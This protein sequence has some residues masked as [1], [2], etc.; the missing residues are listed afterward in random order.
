[1]SR[2]G[3]VG[4]TR[5]AAT[6]VL[7]I[8]LIAATS[9]CSSGPDPKPTAEALAA[10]LASGDL[11][12]V[13]LVG[14]T[15][16]DAATQLE[17]IT[18]GLAGLAPDVEVARIDEGE[19]ADGQEF[20]TVELDVTW[21]PDTATDSGGSSET[22]AGTSWSYT[23]T[24]R[25]SPTDDGWEVAWTPAI[26]H[27][28][29][30]DG[31]RLAV[32]HQQPVRGDILGTG[33]E[34]LVTRR[35]VYRIGIDK[36]QVEPAAAATSAQSLATLVDVDPAAFAGRVDAAGDRAFVEAI[37]LRDAEAVPV[38]ARLE[39]IP[40]AVA[41]EDSIPL[42]PTATFARPILGT[43]G[44]ATAEI[45][46]E[47]GGALAAGDV[48]G[49]SGL[50]ER[51]DD[52]LRG[53]PGT[54]IERIP[55]EGEASIM[56]ETDPVP[57]SALTTTL[58]LAL[59]ERAEAILA[60]VGPASAIVA[61]QPSTGN[62]LAAASGPGGEGYS[63]ATVGQYAPGSTFKVVTSLALLRA[64]LTADTMLQC[65]V[66]TTVDGKSFK[67]YDDYPSDGI[68]EIPLRSVVAN[69][70]NTALIGQQ[71]TVS[72][73]D[74]ASAAASLGLGV[75]HDLGAPTFLGE[76][77]AEADGTEHAASVIGQG[78][79]LAS[80]LAMATVA[81]SIA[82]G[83]T[84]VPRMVEPPAGPTAAP[85]AAPPAGAL[86]AAEGQQ[87]Q[88]LMRAVVE[89]GSGA[90]LADVPGDP[91]GAKTGTAEYGDESPPRTHGWMIATQG[92]LAVAVLVEDAESGS[93]TAG[94]LLEEFLNP[95]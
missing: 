67:N 37:T 81:A 7:A 94:P 20:R 82:Q 66:T 44:A 91:V 65:P 41:L 39:P 31:D 53:R 33:G 19:D 43:V 10:G 35:P 13:A 6:A 29:L 54:T 51:Y 63:T 1:M 45:I 17:E 46:E 57:G 90:F 87:L 14:T 79:V 77:P 86:T 85:A 70:C 56:H 78:L 12:G 42:A 11:T 16:D 62:V 83:T 8:T 64:G 36:T 24:A 22:D 61:V 15:V 80:P 21:T 89:E 3:T 76:V 9:A 95:S 26:I 48:V 2:H 40:G 30:A 27:P 25:L 88:A 34:A 71:D 5:R 23:T 28:D 18:E 73:A 38:I 47:S 55:A 93:Q 52:L 84:V 92:D 49:L 58:D 68:G 59:Q 4:R 69:S 60:A 75:D 50:Q 72:Q 32:R 74:L